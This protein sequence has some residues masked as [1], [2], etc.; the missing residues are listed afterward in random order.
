MAAA[1]QAWAAGR[2]PYLE[3]DLPVVQRIK[4]QKLPGSSSADARVCVVK[5]HFGTNGT[6]GDPSSRTVDRTHD[7]KDSYRR[8]VI[9]QQLSASR[10]HFL[11]R[12]PA[13]HATERRDTWGAADSYCGPHG[14]HWQ[15][16]DNENMALQL[17]LASAPSPY[18]QV[19]L[20]DAI[21]LTIISL[22]L[23]AQDSEVLRPL[24]QLQDSEASEQ[25]DPQRQP[26]LQFAMSR[27]VIVLLL[28]ALTAL[29]MNGAGAP[30]AAV[31]KAPPDIVDDLASAIKLT[32]AALCPQNI[33]VLWQGFVGLAEPIVVGAG[34]SLVIN[35][36]GTDSERG[37]I[38]GRNETQLLRV[39]RGAFV[40]LRNLTLKDGFIAVASENDDGGGAIKVFEGGQLSLEACQFWFNRAVRTGTSAWSRGGAI[41]NKGNVRCLSSA[42]DRNVADYG[43]AIDN[44]GDFD[45]SNS[46]FTSN[47]SDSESQESGGAI[48]NDNGGFFECTASTFTNNTSP[49]SGGAIYNGNATFT[50]SGLRFNNNTAELDGGAILSQ[51]VFTCHNSTLTSNS[52]RWGGAICEYGSSFNCSAS[53]FI[54]NSAYLGGA[55][56][57][58]PSD[59]SCSASTFTD[60]YA[61]FGGA[62][63]SSAGFHC[64]ASTFTFNTAEGGGA[65]I[66]STASIYFDGTF[67]DTSTCSNS[68]FAFNTAAGLGGTGGAIYNEV[69]FTCSGSSFTN[70]TANEGGAIY[71]TGDGNVTCS[72]STFIA[73]NAVSGG[74]IMNAQL[75]SCSNSS[76]TS[77][78][79][80]SGGAIYNNDASFTCIGST[81]TSNTAR[82]FGGAIRT[83]GDLHCIASTFTN[84]SG[85]GGAVYVSTGVDV[86]LVSSHFDDN[87]AVHYGGAIMAEEGA[88]VKCVESKFARSKGGKGAAINLA[89]DATALI[90]GT[91][92][93]FN[94]ATETGGALYLE[95]LVTG[96]INNC[97]FLNN[98]SPVGGALS[99]ATADDFRIFAISD[100]VFAGNNASGG[101][102]GAIIQR[103]AATVLSVNLG[104]STFVDN[105]AQCCYAGVNSAGGK[106]SCAD[107][108]AGYGT[109]WETFVQDDILPCW[110]VGAC[111]GDG[112]NSLDTSDVY[113]SKGYT[114][115][116]CAACAPE[117]ASL[118]G[119]RCVE[120]TGGATA[121]AFTL[122][123]VMTLT[124]LSA[125]WMLVSKA[126]GVDQ[127]VEGGQT[128]SASGPGLKLARA[129][130]L[131]MQRL[132]IPIVVTQVVTQYVSITG[133]S[134]PLQYL[135]F[136][137]AMDFMSLDMRLLTSPGCAA[138]I[139]FYGRL[140]IVTLAP[141]TALIFSPRLYLWVISRYR[142]AVAPK[143]R[144]IVAR[145][146]N[147]FLVLT[148][149]IFSG[150]SLTI[151]E[152]FGCDKLKY[153]Q[154]SFL[155][156]SRLFAQLP[157]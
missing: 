148:F 146:V 125:V 120:C 1:A 54:N 37:V 25:Q 11:G 36:R 7:A 74:A 66:A 127:G 64:S 44:S 81:L 32:E 131:L 119:Y 156:A 107:A 100:C 73:N 84:N 92:F 47:T 2:A 79:G 22:D 49:G 89:H 34:T 85:D 90:D 103:G 65:A 24:Q 134:L 58:E 20:Y 42:F 136:L 57:T 45:C 53:M 76:F 117:Y 109:G 78:T 93:A 87:V 18:Q 99:L 112:N 121:V 59:F 154:E 9:C 83:T 77:N 71:N 95:L 61:G 50:C 118:P 19:D 133:L 141:L 31:C 88:Q 152:T 151:F 14:Q 8:D 139:D 116:Y 143:L 46:T 155:R 62:I 86:H 123:A 35:G 41:H 30:V 147:A 153:S 27:M 104:N 21:T 82:D 115:P 137:Q 4:F 129:G 140:L 108:S 23:R 70:N 5:W 114:G 110:N 63:Y 17:H 6:K 48:S 126:T 56:Y 39:R 16:P 80:E 13:T 12:Q 68:K 113:C 67:R 130:V 144:Q 94:T 149:L 150:V 75:F 60:N 40:A 43:G 51:G 52:A 145:D 98:S 3:D 38:L 29:L 157:R 106:H 69:N 55:I 26:A 111:T 15:V 124:V 135:Q 28:G 72:D 122:L 142:L 33:T 105:M 102:G 96:H 132:R 91:S 97:K 128:I 138:H 101:A 10:K